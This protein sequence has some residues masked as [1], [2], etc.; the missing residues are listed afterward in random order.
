[1]SLRPRKG[2]AVRPIGL[3]PAS[4]YKRNSLRSAC[5]YYARPYCGSRQTLRPPAV[6]FVFHA[7][8][9]IRPLQVAFSLNE[10]AVPDCPYCQLRCLRPSRSPPGG[11]FIA[12]MIIVK[13][14]TAF[15]RD[16]L[17]ENCLIV[18][19]RNKRPPYGRLIIANTTDSIF[20]HAFDSRL[21][22]LTLV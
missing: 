2:G 19:V 9:P 7:A 4:G 3:S 10:P 1:V 21:R 13:L 20:L 22:R 5:S 15:G 8:D 12:P 16:G 14:A 6:T 11:E 18:F 17:S